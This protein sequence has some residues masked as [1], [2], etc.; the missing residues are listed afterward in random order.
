MNNEVIE[1]LD[2]VVPIFI[3]HFATLTPDER[4]AMLTEPFPVGDR[5]LAADYLA[6]HPEER[7]ATLADIIASDGAELIYGGRNFELVFNATAQ[8]LAL[9]AFMPGGI[10]FCGR[11]WCLD[12]ERCET[13]ERGQS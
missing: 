12:H 1:A 8:T 2:G 7:E 9:G 4:H 13:A 11:H 10:T 3:A 6:A 5:G